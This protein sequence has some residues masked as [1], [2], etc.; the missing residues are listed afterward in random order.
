MVRFGIPEVNVTGNGTQFADRGFWEIIKNL[1]IKHH[2]TSTE[3]PQTNGQV[4]AAS[5][6]ILRG[7]KKRLDEAKGAWVEELAYVLWAY[8]TAPRSTTGERP[9]RLMYGTE[10]VILVEVGELTWRTLH[11]LNK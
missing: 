10:V 8:W 3:H 9:Y 1:G 5:R 6:V 2:F 7:L 11:P 4:E